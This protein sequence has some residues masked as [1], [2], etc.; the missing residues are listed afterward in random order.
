MAK[1]GG[2]GRPQKANIRIGCRLAAFWRREGLGFG[3]GAFAFAVLLLRLLRSR[4]SGHRRSDRI[5][6]LSHGYACDAKNQNA[7]ADSGEADIEEGNG[8]LELKLDAVGAWT[9]IN[10]T[11]QIIAA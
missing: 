7:G 10:T 1:R 2:V 3:A 11:H 8:R 9:Q 6:A 4:R 5:Q